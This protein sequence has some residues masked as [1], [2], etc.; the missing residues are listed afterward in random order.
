MNAPT[1]SRINPKDRD[2]A[3]QALRAGVVPRRGIHLVQVGRAAEVDAM[4]RDIQRIADGGGSFRVIVGDYG[5][6]KSFLLNLIK[7]VAHEKNLVTMHADFNPDRRLYGGSG[8]ARSLYNELTRNISTRSSPE[9]GAMKS[10]VAK[11]VTTATLRAKADGISVNQVIDQ[12]LQSL[13]ELV[14]G[15]DFATVISRY[16][17]GHDTGNDV[18]Q[19]DAIRWLRGE[20][21]T[22]TDARAALGVRTAIEDADIYDAIKLLGRF[23][24]LADYSG[25][26]VLLD[27]T[28]NLFKLPSSAA[29]TSNYEQI[30]RILNDSLQG[31]AEGIGWVFG[32]TPDTLTDGRRGLYSYA[33]LQSRLSEN[34]FAAQK[35]VVDVNGPVIRLPSLDATDLYVLLVKIRDLVASASPS[36]PSVPD[37]AVRAFLLHCEQRIGAAYF[38]TPR[39]SVRSWLDLLS[40]LEQHPH[41][42]WT[43]LIAQT[44]VTAE[45][46]PDNDVPSPAG[47]DDELVSFRM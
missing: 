42:A 33:A 32:A 2:A 6:G 5:S 8:Q 29:R 41:L 30:L 22:K 39:N 14:G 12:H 16:W 20:F 28:V 31:S 15:Y 18:L 9:G 19:A 34:S 24:R 44:E 10:I 37:E 3:I 38:Q 43:D 36:L 26:M 13:S 40:V 27:E 17:E 4:V 35:G 7:A 21:Q 47:S 11:F 45:A 46:N 25:T 1:S 23:I